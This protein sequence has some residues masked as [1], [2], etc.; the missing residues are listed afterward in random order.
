MPGEWKRRR[1][2]CLVCVGCQPSGGRFH[3]AV[4]DCQ[5]H[6]SRLAGGM[7]GNSVFYG[8]D[9]DG[10]GAFFR[11]FSVILTSIAGTFLAVLI[12][13]PLAVLTAV[14]CRKWHLRIWRP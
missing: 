11:D 10:K 9:A 7:E 6:T 14:F 2:S 13:V 8:L 5:W 12:G 1:K 3:H 4:Y